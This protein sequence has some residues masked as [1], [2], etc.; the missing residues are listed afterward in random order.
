MKPIRMIAIDL[1]DTLLTDDITVTEHTVRTI[2]RAKQ[3][4]VEVVIATGRMYTTALPYGKMLKLGDIPMMLFSGALIQTVDTGRI[5]YHDPIST[6]HATQLLAL[7][8]EHGWM[9]QTYIDDVLRVPVHNHWIDEYESITG[10]TANVVGDAFYQPPGSPSKILAYGE[11]EELTNMMALIEEAMP[12][13]FTLMRSK[14]TFLEIV[15]K[16]IDKGTGLQHLCD[17]FHIPA[18]NVMAIGNSPNDVG[19]LQRAG[20]SVAVGNAEDK[21]KDMADYITETNNHDGVAAV[22]EKF[23]L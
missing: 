23:I 20:F 13:V 3:K 22:I 10:I 17:Y 21:I 7:A 14:E 1:D 6:A 16:G 15:R 18:E 8:K 9:M 11:K 12:G 19:M 5:L 2:G 4:G